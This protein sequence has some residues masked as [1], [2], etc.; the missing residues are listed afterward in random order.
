VIYTTGYASTTL[1]SLAQ[2]A[3]Q[4]DAL[5]V[6]IRMSAYSRNPQ[7]QRNAMMKRLGRRYVHLPALGNVNYK[8]GRSIVIAD[9]RKGLAYLQSLNRPAILLCGCIHPDTCHRTAVA[10]LLRDRGIQVEE[11]SIPPVDGARTIKAISL[12]QPWATLIALDLKQYE[13]RSWATAYRGLLAIHAAKRKPEEFKPADIMLYAAG[14]RSWGELPLGTVVAIARLVDVI[15]T[16]KMQIETDS[17]ESHFGDFSSG[18]YAWKLEKIHRFASPIPA[19]GAQGLWNWTPP[20]H[21]LQLMEGV[22]S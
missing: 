18:R 2:Y 5:V 15:P 4:L 13:T 10:E 8:N 21:V 14:Y 20:E 22:Q 3:E 7:W 19:R 9:P 6:D 16:D 1:E 17:W 12:W 11:V